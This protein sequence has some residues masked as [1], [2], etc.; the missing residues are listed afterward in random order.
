MGEAMTYRQPVSLLWWTR[1]RSYLI[2]ALRELS[3]VAVAWFVVHFLLLVTAVHR[4]SA[5]YE[6]FLG[7]SASP[8]ILVVNL[9]ALAFVVLHAVTWFSLAPKAMVVRMQG[10]QVPPQM[11]AAGHFGAWVV[12][13]AAVAFVLVVML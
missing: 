1:R 7:W 9:V 5:A 6:E 12:V 3:S 10:Q 8:L 2:F 4:G 11:I 13:S